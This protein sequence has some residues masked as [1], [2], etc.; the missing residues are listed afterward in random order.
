MK[1]KR[2]EVKR[3]RDVSENNISMIYYE[4]DQCVE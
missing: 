2:M 3:R 1:F 4:E